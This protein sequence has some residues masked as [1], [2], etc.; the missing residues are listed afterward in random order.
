MSKEINVLLYGNDDAIGPIATTLNSLV[1]NTERYVNAI[2]L[3]RNWSHSAIETDCYSVEFIEY[4]GHKDTPL[5]KQS[6]ANDVLY[7]LPMLRE[8]D[9]CILLEWDQIVVDNIDEYY[10]VEFS[11]D[12]IITATP[13]QSGRFVDLWPWKKQK[14]N[15]V[16]LFDNE[17]LNYPGFDG[18]SH[19]IDLKKYNEKRLFLEME[20][21]LFRL[22]G[23]DHLAKIGVVHP[24]VKHVD[25]I[26]NMFPEKDNSDTAKIIHY[27]G[28][29]KPWSRKRMK[30]EKWKEYEVSWD[31]MR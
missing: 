6:S 22:N 15:L 16:N 3:C 25:S 13:Y 20:R 29:N 7:I 27:N 31:V 14:Q 30:E 21:A 12:E 18:G 17:T 24:Y 5:Y 2:V 23:E 28:P 8:W 19:V 10:D 26:Y 11:G 9:R 1:I 4:Y